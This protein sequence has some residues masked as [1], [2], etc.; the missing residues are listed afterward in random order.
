V[1]PPAV[2]EAFDVLEYRIREFDAGVPSLAIWQLGLHA[3]PE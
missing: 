3:S 2:V 1:A